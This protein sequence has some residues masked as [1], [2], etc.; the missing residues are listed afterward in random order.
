MRFYAERPLRVAWQLLADVLVI[1]WAWLVVRFAQAAQDLIDQLQGP[2]GALRVGRADGAR[3][4]RRRRADGVAGS[5]SWARTW[6]RRSTSAPGPGDSLAAAGQ[7]QAQLIDTVGLWAAVAIVAFAAVP[8]VL[9]WLVR[10]APVRAHGGL[11]GGR[12]GPRPRP[13]RPPRARPPADSAAAAGV[14]R[15]G[16]G[17]AA[18]RH[19]RRARA[20]G[21]GAARVGPAG[22]PTPVSPWRARRERSAGACRAALRGSGPRRRTPRP[23]SRRTS[24]NGAS[25][26]PDEACRG[27]ARVGGFRSSG[28]RCPAGPVMDRSSAVVG[29]VSRP[30]D[31]SPS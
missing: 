2:A 16:G 25:P 6:R 5:R 30:P 22:A 17:V 3:H 7:R 11:G 15:P 31:R 19:R 12:A 29:C 13:P 24:S 28:R 1:A 8:V 4:V 18:R 9:L 20:R 10:A 14:G 27:R 23:G 26:Q 21:V